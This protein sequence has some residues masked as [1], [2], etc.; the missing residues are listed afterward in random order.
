M[1]ALG[2]S[3]ISTLGNRQTLWQLW[4]GQAPT[5]LLEQLHAAA[6]QEEQVLS[7]GS[8]N[9]TAAKSTGPGSLQEPR[10]PEGHTD[11]PRAAA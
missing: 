10:P 8:H 3:C 7:T 4:P 6:W 5:H 1:E 9:K 11:N 2:S